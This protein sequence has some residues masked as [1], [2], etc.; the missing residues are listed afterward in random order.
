LAVS[1]VNTLVIFTSPLTP[2]SAAPVCPPAEDSSALLVEISS[3]KLSILTNAGEANMA[4]LF[5][6]E[7]EEDKEEE[8]DLGLLMLLLDKEAAAREADWTIS[9]EE[10][11]RDL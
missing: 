9:L 7:E 1:A 10:P 3:T 11:N 5:E 6:E 4:G 8:D 2:A